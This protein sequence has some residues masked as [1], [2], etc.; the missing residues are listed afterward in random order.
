LECRGRWCLSTY[1]C[2]SLASVFQSDCIICILPRNESEILLLFI[3]N[4]NWYCQFLRIIAVLIG[5]YLHLKLSLFA[6]AIILYAQNPKTPQMTTQANN[7]F[8]KVTSYKTNT[9]K[10]V[11]FLYTNKALSEKEI[12]GNKFNMESYMSS[13]EHTRSG[14]Q[15]MFLDWKTW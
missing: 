14:K 9:H 5:R 2:K 10:S 7:K 4:S 15:L 8:S 13:K 6:D 3:F 12:Y 1:P 11:I